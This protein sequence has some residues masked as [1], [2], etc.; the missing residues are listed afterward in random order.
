MPETPKPR[1]AWQKDLARFFAR[2]AVE[3]SIGGLVVVSVILTLFEFALEV[4]PDGG[5]D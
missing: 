1:A 4:P 3:L 2:P 5:V